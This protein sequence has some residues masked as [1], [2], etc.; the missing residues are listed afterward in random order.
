MSTV[1][2]IFASRTTTTA[3]RKP[4]LHVGKRYIKRS[5]GPSVSQVLFA[6]ALGVIVFE[7]HATPGHVRESSATLLLS[8]LYFYSSRALP[9]QQSPYIRT[10]VLHYYLHGSP[11]TWN[12]PRTGAGEPRPSLSSR[13]PRVLRRIPRRILRCF[14]RDEYLRAQYSA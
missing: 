2:V 4:Q 11:S 7:E 13:P 10:C 14:T 5:V 6:A 9:F 8:R 1:T 12:T 3:V